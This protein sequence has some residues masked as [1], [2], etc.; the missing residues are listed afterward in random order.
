[1]LLIILL[2]LYRNK[3]KLRKQK[4]QLELNNR[5]AGLE[6]QVVKTQM[7]PH[8]ISNCLAAIQELMYDNKIDK[9]GQYIA[10]FSLFVRQVL[11]YSDKASITL[12]EELEL[13]KLNV[14]LEQ[15]RFRDSFEFNVDLA[16]GL[17]LGE[18]TIPSLITQPIVENA[19]WHGLLPLREKRRPILNIRLYQKNGSLFVEVEDNGKGRDVVMVKQKVSRGTRLINDR[20]E[21]LRRL[22]GSANYKM[23]VIDL[24]DEK[25]EASGTKVILQVENSNE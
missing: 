9:A 18:V 6:M 3:Q 13:I 2:M 19:I 7:N 10:K 21:I 1:V 5:I 8:F 14:E 17:N 4:E 12:N 20:L 11:N 15:L 24:V 23:E 22:S 16:P 25:G